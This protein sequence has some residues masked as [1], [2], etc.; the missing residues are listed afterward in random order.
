VAHRDPL[1]PAAQQIDSVLLKQ[2]RGQNSLFLKIAG[3]NYFIWSQV[4]VLVKYWY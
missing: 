4:S 1:L 2:A 3:E